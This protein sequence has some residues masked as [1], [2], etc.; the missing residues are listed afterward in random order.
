VAEEDD[1]ERLRAAAEVLAQHDRA[2]LT[3]LEERDSAVAAALQAGNSWRTVQA[4]AGLS[5]RGLELAIQR[6][7]AAGT[8][9]E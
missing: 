6:H 2:R 1:V 3:L 8:Q 7:R 4:T 9:P 5:K